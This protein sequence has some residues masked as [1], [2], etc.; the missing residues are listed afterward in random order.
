MSG[1]AAVIEEKASRD[2]R[3]SYEEY[4]K[5]WGKRHGPREAHLFVLDVRYRG[6]DFGLPVQDA[7]L[8]LAGELPSYW[9][10]AK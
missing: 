8:A 7:V 9:P 2:L 10:A 4:L 1:A 3:R 6:L 5:V